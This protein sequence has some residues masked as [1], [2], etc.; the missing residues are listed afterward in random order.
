MKLLSFIRKLNDTSLLIKFSVIFVILLIIAFINTTQY[1]SYKEKIDDTHA[2]TLI[3]SEMMFQSQQIIMYSEFVLRE[4]ESSKI[5]LERAKQL[6]EKNLYL[7]KNGGVLNNDF[8]SNKIKALDDISKIKLSKLEKLWFSIKENT[9]SIIDEETFIGG[10]EM[11]TGFIDVSGEYVVE[12]ASKPLT[13]EVK[14]AVRSLERTN[15]KFLKLNSEIYE[16]HE[17]LIIELNNSRDLFVIILF[18]VM[19]FF[20]LFCLFII[21]KLIINRLKRQM[22]YVKEVSSGNYNA[23]F[24][25]SMNDEIGQIG[26]HFN[27]FALHIKG[28]VEYIKNISKGNLTDNFEHNG[29]FDV[30]SETL[31]VLKNTLVDASTES[32][33][34]NQEDN[35]RRWA[36]EGIAKF[37]EILR[38]NNNNIAD[39]SYNILINLI[40]YIDANIGGMFVMYEKDNAKYFNLEAAYALDRR[41]FVTKELEFSEGLIGRCA[42]ERQCLY[43]TEL[44]SDY[45]EIASGL[46]TSKP[47]SILLSPLIYNNEVYGV[48]ELA[49]FKEIEDYKIDFVKKVSE[50]IASTISSVKVNVRTAQLLSE[51]KQQAERLSQQEEEM[52]Q[53]LEEMQATQEGAATKTKEME[54]I[55]NEISQSFGVYT[56][57]LEGDFLSANSIYTSSIGISAKSIYDLMHKE[58]VKNSFKNDKEYFNFWNHIANGNKEERDIVYI[59]KSL[60]PIILHELYIPIFDTYGDISKIN[61]ITYPQNGIDPSLLNNL[62]PNNVPPHNDFEDDDISD[63]ETNEIHTDE[64]VGDDFDIEHDRPANLNQSMIEDPYSDN[65]PEERTE[66]KSKNTSIPETV[67]ITETV[68]DTI[69]ETNTI[70]ETVITWNDNLLLNHSEFDQQH[71]NIFTLLS[72]ISH[73]CFADNEFKN[74]KNLHAQLFES[75]LINFKSEEKQFTEYNFSEKELHKL[76]HRDILDAF[77]DFEKAHNAGDEKN[78]YAFY[79]KIYEWFN[80]HISTED[81]KYVNEFKVAKESAPVIES[82]NLEAELIL[83]MEWSDALA[84]NLD[85]IDDQHKIL[86]DLINQIIDSHTENRAKKNIKGYLKGLIDYTE[87]HFAAEEKHIKSKKKELYETHREQHNA[88][89]MKLNTFQKDFNAGNTKITNTFLAEIIEW[90]LTHISESDMQL[91]H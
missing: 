74:I 50:S 58:L 63:F 71:K 28:A 55:F 38:S 47:V 4:V 53:N 67:N 91:K 84:V 81:C 86:F 90:W 26:T 30:L 89:L 44:P 46:G 73:K 13:T 5:N 64:A 76:L 2:K 49:A 54:G 32:E 69:P 16:Y 72:E 15:D 33:K 75:I 18:L 31:T 7:L 6:Y 88:F 36:T 21:N 29:E 1:F 42:Q 70:P 52:R 68:T 17:K 77:D 27:G 39:L 45:I 78:L 24:K 60:Q 25:N 37:G 3:L 59:L 43:L 23:A 79:I 87:Y 22:A 40:E 41:K 34:R 66:T 57:N 11:A 51:S 85:F 8:Y 48:I 61:V 83:P 80:M 14:N 12:D 19:A 35:I 62:V 10:S 82:N 20:V 9:E 56:V 65:I